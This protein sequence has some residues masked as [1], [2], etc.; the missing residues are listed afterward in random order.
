[1]NQKKSKTVKSEE[2]NKKSTLDWR[3][4]RGL[5]ITK[6]YFPQII[7]EFFDGVYEEPMAFG[8]YYE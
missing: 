3:E 1:M 2:E 5:P 7:R 8:R 4:I 6:H